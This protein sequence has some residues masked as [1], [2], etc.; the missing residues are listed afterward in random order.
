MIICARKADIGKTTFCKVFYQKIAVNNDPLTTVHRLPNE[1]E[2]RN[3]LNTLRD[4]TIEELGQKQFEG[5]L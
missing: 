4:Q 1:R 3:R 2:I 5:T